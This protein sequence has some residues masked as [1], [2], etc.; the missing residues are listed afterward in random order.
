MQGGRCAAM[1]APHN[2]KQVGLT[3]SFSDTGRQGIGSATA[4]PPA[5]ALSRQRCVHQGLPATLERPL[6]PSAALPPLDAT[7]AARHRSLVRPAME[8]LYEFIEGSGCVVAFAD[9][10]GRLLDMLGDAAT[11]REVGELG[12]TTSMC[13]SEECAG[14]N[15]LALALIESFPTQVL[16]AQ[17]YGAF[18]QAYSTT[19]APVHDSLG[20]L[21]GA[22]AVIGRAE[23]CTTHTLGMVSAAATALTGELRMNR[24]LPSERR[25]RRLLRRAEAARCAW[26]CAH[27]AQH[28]AGAAPGAAH[29]RS[30]S[31]HVVRAHRRAESRPVGGRP[32]RA[33]R[34]G[35][36]LHG[37]AA[38]RD[39]DGQRDLRAKHPQWQRARRRPL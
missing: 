7:W 10:E 27:A 2:G 36:Q 35:G 19:G 31:P 1:Q 30:A 21:V 18:A 24:C 23:S 39:R 12:F 29:E 17:H 20:S 8:D 34:G 33:H 22:L 3:D 6:A 32:A 26:L 37:L 13:W 4:I 38:R 28:R 16:G 11:L 25:A 9:A 5:I 14:T 15:G